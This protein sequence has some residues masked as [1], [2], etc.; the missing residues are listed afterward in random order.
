MCS[1]DLIPPRPLELVA[2]HTHG[3]VQ[4][5]FGNVDADISGPG[6]TDQ[7]RSGPAQV[8]RPDVDA[9]IDGGAGSPRALFAS[10]FSDEA[11]NVLFRLYPERLRPFLPVSHELHP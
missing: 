3:F 7:Q 11:V 8:Q 5:G 2:Q 10:R 6:M 4:N 9:G 1:S